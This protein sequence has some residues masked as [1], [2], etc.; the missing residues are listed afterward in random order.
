MSGLPES[1]H[2][3]AVTA[4]RKGVVRAIGRCA[5]VRAIQACRKP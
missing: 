5:F 1:G 2:L 3:R 4:G